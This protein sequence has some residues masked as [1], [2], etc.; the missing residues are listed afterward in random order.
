MRE[1]G[2]GCIFSALILMNHELRSSGICSYRCISCGPSNCKH[3][4]GELG[5]YN[6]IIVDTLLNC[7]IS[8]QF[9]FVWYHYFWNPAFIYNFKDRQ[10]GRAAAIFSR[11]KRSPQLHRFPTNDSS[12]PYVSIVGLLDIL[13]L[14]IIFFLRPFPFL[15]CTVFS[16]C[17]FVCWKKI[18]FTYIVN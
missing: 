5:S 15:T 3:F 10:L 8:P 18:S 4:Q 7:H 17:E 9:G 2:L 12:L 13:L 1:E 11:W 14:I 16:I 6:R